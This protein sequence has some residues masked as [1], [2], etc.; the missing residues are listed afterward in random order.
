MEKVFEQFRNIGVVPVIAIEDASK[1]SLLASALVKGGIHIAEITFRTACAEEAI[2]E[3]I[4]AE[5]HMLVGAGT[6][7]NVE[8]TER[9]VKAGAKFIVSPGYNPDVVDWCIANNV[10]TV[11]G[12]SNASEIMAC[13]NKG[14]SVL[15]L[16]PA[17]RLG[18]CK[19][20]DDF[21]GPFPHVSFL[22]TG[23]VNLENLIDYAKR[24]N[25]LCVGGTWMVKKNLIEDNKWDEISQLCSEAV[26][27]IHD[28]RRS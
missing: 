15:K 17:E 26:K 9:A 11:P 22:P 19:I 12:V 4:K 28:I 1:A 14:L 20:V 16:F 18:G 8:Q 2:R 21:G 6:V 10:P 25:V 5:P 27:V 24:K 13:V 3:M 23:G 7:L